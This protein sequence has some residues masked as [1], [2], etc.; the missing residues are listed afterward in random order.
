MVSKK[1]IQLS[2]SFGAGLGIALVLLAC[3]PA[4]ALAEP[5]WIM[6][7]KQHYMDEDGFV[8]DPSG[9]GRGNALLWTC[10]YYVARY[11]RGEW[12]NVGDNPLEKFRETVRKCLYNPEKYP[13]IFMRH[14]RDWR[15]TEQDDYIALAAASHVVD[16]LAHE[17]VAI[18]G[19]G[20]LPP[21]DQGPLPF[22]YGWD[23]E[24]ILGVDTKLP[25]FLGRYMYVP[26]TLAMAANDWGLAG[27]AALPDLLIPVPVSPVPVSSRGYWGF[28]FQLSMTLRAESDLKPG[29][30][31]FGENWYL[32]W[33]MAQTVDFRS[34][35]DIQAATSLFMMKLKER[36]GNEG[37]GKVL[38]LYWNSPKQHPL[39][40]A[41]SNLPEPPPYVP[42]PPDVLTDDTFGHV[43]FVRP[44]SFSQNQD[45]KKAY[46]VEFPL[47]PVHDNSP[48]ASFEIVHDPE[49]PSHPIKVYEIDKGG[50]N[51]GDFSLSLSSAEENQW[52]NGNIVFHV[53][54]NPTANGAREATIHF[55]MHHTRPDGK[56]EDYIR[57]VP[58]FRLRAVA[59]PFVDT[60]GHVAVVDPGQFSQD[61]DRRGYTHD[62]GKVPL[63]QTSGEALFEIRHD[64][65]GLPHPL[66]VSD[67]EVVGDRDDFPMAID[68][69]NVGQWFD[70]NIVIRVRFRPNAAGDRTASIHLTLRHRRL[71]GRGD[72][73]IMDAPVFHLRGGGGVGSTDLRDLTVTPTTVTGG[74]TASGSVKLSAAAPAGGAPVTLSTTNPAAF[75]PSPVTVPE[76]ATSA[77]FTVA[78][79]AVSTAVNGSVTASYGGASKSAVLT[80]TPGRS[81]VLNDTPTL[82]DFWSTN[83]LAEAPGG[84][85]F[86]TLN[87]EEGAFSTATWTGS[88][89][90][91]LWQYRVEA[92]I[93]RQGVTPRTNQAVYRIVHAGVLGETRQTV[94][95]QVATSQW[96]TLGTFPFQGSYSV[97]LTDET[98][99]PTRTRSVAA[100]AIRL[101]PVP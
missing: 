80:V 23:I 16:P 86:A 101:T 10:L 75:V 24:K 83:P 36:F 68:S 49:G 12:E 28:G 26:P 89:P 53:R 15:F 35:P 95:Q 27:L 43:A 38:D 77:T 91:D 7:I 99:E 46:E 17:A 87:S 82:T 98:G 57:D 41:L 47:T 3:A 92:F 5:A 81:V 14:P 31:Q 93:P 30:D 9:G 20:L 72:D 63:G 39:A 19:Y 56:G 58:E 100:D 37:V 65:P 67:L 42:G 44:N 61:A 76:G 1:R 52:F 70:G 73:V 64:P 33:L 62:F 11:E 60:F 59:G 84:R 50:P 96:T 25:S 69:A 18:Y 85:Y 6:E 8:T 13:G 2:R 74:Q 45:D 66:M 78:T 51:A 29:D 94:N 4:P 32:G 79:I 48:E 97:V 54:F 34:L 21:L 22:S 55:K 88:L 71:D 40:W 90:Q